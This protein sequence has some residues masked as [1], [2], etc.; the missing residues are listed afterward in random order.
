MANDDDLYLT[1]L[2]T[3]EMQGWAEF[4]DLVEKAIEDGTAEVTLPTDFL[5]L[6]LPDVKHIPDKFEALRDVWNRVCDE[7][8][9]PEE[10]RLPR[11]ALADDEGEDPERPF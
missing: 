2:N 5:A 6:I 7:Q 10:K 11:P 1:Y 8:G 4:Q 9:R 3:P